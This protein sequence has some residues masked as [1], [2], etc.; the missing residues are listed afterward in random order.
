MGFDDLLQGH[1]SQRLESESGD[2]VVWRRDGL[3]AYHLAV[4]VD[5][6]L[7]G[8]TDIVRGIDLMDSS[9]RQ[10]WLQRLLG[11]PSPRYA[12]IPVA[13]NAHGQKLSKTTG[14]RPLPLDDPRR[15]L[16]RAFAAL[17]QSPPADLASCSLE[18]VW[19]WAR[20]NWDIAR[21]RGTA[22]VAASV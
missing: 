3:V 12:H 14:A 13:V 22:S 8:V 7:A 10:I 21:L 19:A 9:P 4:V 6:A 2:F 1:Q 18:D 15:T 5:D 20:D 11:H 16:V 17:D